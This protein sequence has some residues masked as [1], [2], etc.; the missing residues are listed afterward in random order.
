VVELLEYGPG[1]LTDTFDQ[2]VGTVEPREQV[3]ATDMAKEDITPVGRFF[4]GVGL[5]RL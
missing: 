3:V 2:P 5:S 4:E 1:P